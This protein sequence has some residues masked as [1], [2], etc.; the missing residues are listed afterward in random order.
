[1]IQALHKVGARLLCQ[2]HPSIL[3]EYGKAQNFPH[4]IISQVRQYPS[5]W[6][7]PKQHPL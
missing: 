1:M 5:I 7:M 4:N 3:P 6:Q 2:S